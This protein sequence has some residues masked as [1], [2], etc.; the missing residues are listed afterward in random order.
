MTSGNGNGAHDATYARAVPEHKSVLQ[1]EFVMGYSPLMSKANIKRTAKSPGEL[2]DLI[3]I[4]PAM[5]RDFKLLGV[6]SVAALARQDPESIYKK[7][8]RVTGQQQDICALDTFRA[9][10]AQA[11]NPRLPGKQCQWWYW[12]RRRKASKKR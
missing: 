10:V 9:A 8:C 4:G 6:D 11:R 3:S 7:L 1:I 12:S 5:V 2:R